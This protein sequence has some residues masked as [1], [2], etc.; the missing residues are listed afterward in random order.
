MNNNLRIFLICFFASLLA[1]S[2]YNNKKE[3]GQD[4]LCW[5]G[6][7]FDMAWYPKIQKEHCNGK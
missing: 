6:E 2:C 5:Y 7:T 4:F 1:E 3:W